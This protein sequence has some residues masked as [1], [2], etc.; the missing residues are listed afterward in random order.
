MKIIS[1]ILLLATTFM[2]VRHGWNGLHLNDNPQQLEMLTRLGIPRQMV[3]PVSIMNLV[4]GIAVLFPASFFFA[5]MIHAVLF[6]QIICF[7]L[8][9]GEIKT[10]LIEIPFLLMPLVLIYL[11]HPFKNQ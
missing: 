7:S 6:V 9:S 8:R 5:N 3:L 10:A 1:S 11:G 2:T 4:I